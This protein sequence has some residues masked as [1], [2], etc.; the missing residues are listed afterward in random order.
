[1][2]DK[3]GMTLN[4]LLLRVSFSKRSVSECSLKIACFVNMIVQ[5]VYIKIKSVLLQSALHLY[6]QAW[7]KKLLFLLWNSFNWLYKS[8]ENEGSFVRSGNSAPLQL[9][10]Y[11][12]KVY[13][14]NNLIFSNLLYDDVNNNFHSD[15]YRL[16]NLVK[17][18]KGE[19]NYRT[20]WVCKIKAMNEVIM[21]KILH[22][23]KYFFLCSY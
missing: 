8:F 20:S 5:L 18:F 16:R 21:S 17:G 6:F 7:I 19:S 12:K 11:V 13:N 22:G 23:I 1:M 14:V 3:Y 9:L 4:P 15:I 2:S 10:S